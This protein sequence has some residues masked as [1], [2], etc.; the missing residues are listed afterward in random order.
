M[1]ELV[2]TKQKATPQNLFPTAFAIGIVM[3]IFAVLTELNT[4]PPGVYLQLYTLAF[5]INSA[6]VVCFVY[7]F[8]RGNTFARIVVSIVLLPVL[9]NIFS[10]LWSISGEFKPLHV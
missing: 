8:Q 2:A 5:V 7:A 6:A 9:W 10:L 3:F 4:V 1:L